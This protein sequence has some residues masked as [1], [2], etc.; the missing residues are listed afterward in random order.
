MLEGVFYDELWLLDTDKLKWF[1]VQQSDFKKMAQGGEK[2]KRRKKKED[3]GE[4]N[5]EMEEEEDEI[6]EEKKEMEDRS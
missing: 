5:A 3:G 4:E 2:K 6:Q 1:P